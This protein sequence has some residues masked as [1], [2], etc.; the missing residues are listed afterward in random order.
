M[1]SLI[2]KYK[3]LGNLSHA[4]IKNLTIGSHKKIKKIGGRRLKEETKWRAILVKKE[5][6]LSNWQIAARRKVSS[7]TV[8]PSF[9]FVVH[10]VS[11]SK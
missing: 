1:L 8:K 6:H 10:V 7:S 5:R 9:H 3:S 11:I 2:Y 4:K